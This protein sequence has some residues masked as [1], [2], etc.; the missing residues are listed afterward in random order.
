MR[1]FGGSSTVFFV[2]GFEEAGAPPLAPKKERISGMLLKFGV[3]PSPSSG[4]KK[5]VGGV[6]KKEV[7]FL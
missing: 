3:L 2:A 4:I 5:K 7:V 1:F 6:G